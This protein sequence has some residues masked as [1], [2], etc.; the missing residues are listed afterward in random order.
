MYIGIKKRVNKYRE[1][2]FYLYLCES[3]RIE[4]RVTNKQRYLLSVKERDLMNGQYK[5]LF[6]TKL[7]TLDNEVT[8]A[9]E[10]K[11]KSILEESRMQKAI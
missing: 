10:R 4:G 3:K 1:Q 11:V 9:L 7:I 5:D 6:S 2:V 8:Q